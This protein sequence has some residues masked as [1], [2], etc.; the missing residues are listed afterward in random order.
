MTTTL[1]SPTEAPDETTG[2]S[3]YE[4]PEEGG[5]VS[6]LH[7]EAVTWK[8]QPA[9]VVDRHDGTGWLPGRYE[10]REAAVAAASVDTAT[11]H[12]IVGRAS[13]LVALADIERKGEPEPP[14]EWDGNHGFRVWRTEPFSEY[15]AGWAVELPHKCG[16]WEIAWGTGDDAV[17]EALAQLDEFIA[18]AQ[19]AREALAAGREFGEAP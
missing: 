1:T 8:D 9:F 5:S 12:R 7:I 14:P 6:D 10:T 11:L 16:P 19:Q 13:G 15:R 2:A 18:Q 3:S 17:T 4:D